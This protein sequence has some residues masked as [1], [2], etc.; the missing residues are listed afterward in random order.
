[1]IEVPLYSRPVPMWKD[2]SVRGMGQCFLEDSCVM[3]SMQFAVSAS[4]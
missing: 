2:H 3:V 1:M 4:A